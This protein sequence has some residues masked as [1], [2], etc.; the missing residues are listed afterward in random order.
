MY[1]NQYGCGPGY[2]GGNHLWQQAPVNISESD[3]GFTIQLHAP[4]LDKQHISLTT[5]NDILHIRYKGDQRTQTNFT[6]REYR[7]EEIERSFDLKG[8]VNT[9]LITATYKEGILTVT[10]PKNDAA[11]KPLQEVQIN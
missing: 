10:L 4:G 1:Y 6:R 5:Q 11:K 3:E 7:T 8:K 9:E 2:R